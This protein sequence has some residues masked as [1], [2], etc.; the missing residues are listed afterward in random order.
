M[1]DNEK[2]ILGQAWIFE[3]K[4][5][6][7]QTVIYP[8][9]KYTENTVVLIDDIWDNLFNHGGSEDDGT[10]YK[11]NGKG[12]FYWPI[13]CTPLYSD[14]ETVEVFIECP[15]PREDE[16]I[17]RLGE[18]EIQEGEDTTQ[19]WAK[20]WKKRLDT[21]MENVRKNLTIQRKEIILPGTKWIDP[22]GNVQ[23]TEEKVIQTDHEL[24]S[25]ANLLMMF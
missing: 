25:I 1:N 6:Q 20:Y 12:Y 19:E 3:N 14:D 18:V 2:I 7:D 16:Q 8:G 17:E 21:T 24:G 23:E 4:L 5:M 11:T 10:Q 15:K 9:G 13:K 22:E